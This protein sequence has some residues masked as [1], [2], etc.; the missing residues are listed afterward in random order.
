MTHY[1]SYAEFFSRALFRMAEIDAAVIESATELRVRYGF[2]T[3]D[4]IHLATAILTGDQALAKCREV[5][6][7]VIPL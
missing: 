6:V 2:R 5:A 7:E 1:T 4:A 3:P